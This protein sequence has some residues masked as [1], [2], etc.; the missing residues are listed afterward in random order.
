M[1]DG[2]TVK[3]AFI[4]NLG[5]N[6]DIITRPGYNSREVLLNCTNALKAHFNIENWAINQPINISSLYT[7]LDRIKGVQTVQDITFETKVGNSYSS[8]DYDVKGAIKNNILYP[9]LDPMI[10]EIKFPNSDI[11]GRITTL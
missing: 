9:S 11:R 3:D 5:I 7:I 6:Y 8:Y 10:F 1:T 4:I 2:C